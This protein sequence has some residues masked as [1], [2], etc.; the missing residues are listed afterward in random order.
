MLKEVVFLL[1]EM[2]FRIS[3]EPHPISLDR[4]VGQYKN[5]DSTN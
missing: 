2:L 5:A 4:S 3:T 1:A